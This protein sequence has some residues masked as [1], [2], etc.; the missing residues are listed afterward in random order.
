MPF[1][2]ACTAALAASNSAVVTDE[3]RTDV[4]QERCI[5]GRQTIARFYSELNARASKDL[6]RLADKAE[7]AATS[8]EA[9][10]RYLPMGDDR[11]ERDRLRVRAAD[12]LFIAA[13]ARR[14][15]GQV[16]QQVDD[17]QTVLEILARLDS[18]DRTRSTSTLY[19][20]ARLLQA[21]SRH[22]LAGVIR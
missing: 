19:Q 17:L 5:S 4:R 6:Q 1:I 16:S 3:G 12:A 14:R 13:E 8:L 15:L 9:C 7:A 18:Q 22:F 21:Y 11:I 20:E 10:S 2:A